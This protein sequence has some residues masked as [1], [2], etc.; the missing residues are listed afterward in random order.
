MEEVFYEKIYPEQ[1]QTPDEPLV[2]WW[3]SYRVDYYAPSGWVNGSIYD[4]DSFRAYRDAVYLNG[5]RF[6]DDLRNLIGDE[7]FFD[8]LRDYASRNL[9]GIA[10]T[11]SFFDILREHTSQNMDNLIT[12]YFQPAK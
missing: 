7:V 11:A 12:E 5:A 9:Y 8:F 1:T 2:D 10:T 4:Y 3:W 6:L